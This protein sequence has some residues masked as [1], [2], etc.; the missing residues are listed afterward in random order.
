MLRERQLWHMQHQGLM[1]DQRGLQGRQGGWQ[2]H[3][4]QVEVKHFGANGGPELT[5]RER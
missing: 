5:D 3:V 4:G 1:L 2:H